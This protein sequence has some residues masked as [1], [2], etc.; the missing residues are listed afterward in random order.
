MEETPTLLRGR[1]PRGYQY[2]AH[3]TFAAPTLRS[4]MFKLAA[5]LAFALALAAC[6]A[7]NTVTEGFSQAK[8]VESDLETATGIRPKVGFNWNNGRLVTVTVQFPRIQGS[9]PLGELAQ[10]V[11]S[12]VTT[13]FKQ[14]PENIVL[15]FSLGK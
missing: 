5:A 12:S 14:T 2:A 13:Q 9:K 7:V 1:A 10:T 3:V 6:D 15:A 8:A 4:S 11:R